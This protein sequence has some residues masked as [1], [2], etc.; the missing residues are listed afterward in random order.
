MI[1]GSLEVELLSNILEYVDE[2]SPHTVKSL[3]LVN[4]HIYATARRVQFRRQSVNL[5]DPCKAESRL[6]AYLAAPEA[7]RNIRQLTILGHRRRDLSD[8]V[9]QISATFESLAKLVRS[10]ANLRCI[11]WCYTGP[12]PI[13]VLDA[14]H[15]YHPRASLMI[16]NWTRASNDAKHDDAAELALANS[17]ALTYFQ[18]SIWNQ[19]SG[20]YP[21]LREA[22]CKRIIANAPNL[23]Y[24]S[25]TR[26]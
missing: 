10:L 8:E 1:L 24:A 21:D 17:P 12:I 3:S 16:Y 13:A 2:A 18:A 15:R 6:S 14:I 25:V 4:K 26:G 5:T 11:L 9:S 23:R 19:G 7:L 22:A 20:S